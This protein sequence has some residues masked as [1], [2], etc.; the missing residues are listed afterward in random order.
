M[1]AGSGLLSTNAFLSYKI[2][3]DKFNWIQ[4]WIVNRKLSAEIPISI[5]AF[6]S[7][8]KTNIQLAGI[9]PIYFKMYLPTETKCESCISFSALHFNSEYNLILREC[10]ISLEL[11]RYWVYSVCDVTLVSYDQQKKPRSRNI[12][13][14]QMRSV[15]KKSEITLGKGSSIYIKRSVR[16]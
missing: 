1:L 7:C 2:V 3:A 9:M 5:P 12:F 16:P 14:N 13:R 6:A 8:V 4:N 10:A 15:C 11:V